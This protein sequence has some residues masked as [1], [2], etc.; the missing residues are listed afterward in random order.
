M[1]AILPKTTPKTAL[2]PHEALTRYAAIEE[3]INVFQPQAL[4]PDDL[5]ELEYLEGQLDRAQQM[6]T[7]LSETLSTLWDAATNEESDH[8]DM[9]SAIWLAHEYAAMMSDVACAHGNVRH[10][11]A[12]HYQAVAGGEA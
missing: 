1:K 2:Q 8:R 9:H 7:A 4:A 6:A 11:I 12:L 5:E 3:A 10:R